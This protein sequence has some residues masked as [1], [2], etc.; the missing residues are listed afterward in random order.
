MKK[1]IFWTCILITFTSV[2]LVVAIAI[3]VMYSNL[4]YTNE[5]YLSEEAGHAAA[6]L[7]SGGV[8]A[9]QVFE[10]RQTRVTL[11]ARDGTVLYDS[12]ENAAGMENH[13]QRKEILLAR[14][15]GSAL[16]ERYSQTL[17]TKTIYYALL[18]DDG[19]VLRVSTTIQKA[20]GPLIDISVYIIVLGIVVVVLT[21][22]AA[23]Y[24]TKKI[25]RPINEL[26]LKKPLDNFT[27]AEFS[28][29]LRRISAQNREIDRHIGAI[30][31]Q[32]HEFKTLTQ[33]MREGFVMLN[34]GRRVVYA[35]QNALNIL[36]EGRPVAELEDFS[37]LRHAR[38]LYE[39]LPKTLAEPSC[40]HYAEI[41]NKWYHVVLNAFGEGETP[42]G[43][44]VLLWDETQQ[45]QAAALRREF[46]A[47]VS[48]ELRTPLTAIKGYAELIENGMA[49]EKDISDFAVKISAEATRLVTLVDDIMRL[50]RLDEGSLSEEYQKIDLCLAAKQ[51]VARLKDYAR[52]NDVLLKLT[53]ESA[54]VN[55]IPSVVDEM[56]FNLCENAIKY[57]RPGGSVVLQ[58]S[59]E[60]DR[61]RLKVSDTGIGIPDE[62]K[63]K[64]FERFYRVDKSHSRKTGG[65]G[66]GLSIV[67][68]GAGLHEAAIEVESKVGRG[69]GISVI[70]E[71]A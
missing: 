25:M 4:E 14:E 55:A 20:A 57:N 5:T 41:E 38:Q 26:D 42:G 15:N 54:A 35:N 18:L 17:G 69:T 44:T 7:G 11:V 71:E 63:E 13:N 30:K 60:G 2:A 34:H 65:T 27:Y 47:N 9:L 6:L 58:V 43:Y 16:Y 28:P 39:W 51:V 59:R 52:E 68:H 3:G 33:K 29:L 46:S 10:D 8:P 40:E 1:R 61:V 45:K 49:E 21:G 12:S 22:I 62:Y 32:E 36:N 19:R 23:D 66:L 50:S 56:I 70:F 67:K 64:I 24:V 37:A 53:G 48:H 31:R